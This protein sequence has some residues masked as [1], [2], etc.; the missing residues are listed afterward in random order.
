MTCEFYSLVNLHQGFLSSGL[1]GGGKQGFQQA[2]KLDSFVVEGVGAKG[3]VQNER[4]LGY[5]EV[6]LS[7]HMVPQFVPRV[8][9]L[10]A[11]FFQRLRGTNRAPFHQA[12]F[13]SMQWLF[14]IRE[15][16]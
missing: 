6:A 9:F 15:N 4:K 11:C 3:T 1:S 13:Q 7:G 8:R 12:A 14:G 2:P 16:P 10:E 5:I